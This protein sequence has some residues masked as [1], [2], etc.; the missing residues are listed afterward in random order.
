MRQQALDKGYACLV[1]CWFCNGAE[2][3]DRAK[4][5][6]AR[7]LSLLQLKAPQRYDLAAFNRLI[8]PHAP[9]RIL[10]SE[11]DSYDWN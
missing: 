1:A 2:L 5:P 3:H 10:Q 4:W 7:Q 9:N 6:D 8:N 11:V